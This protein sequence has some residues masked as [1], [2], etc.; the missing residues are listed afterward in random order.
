MSLAGLRVAHARLRLA[1]SAQEE[2]V[3]R[4]RFFQELMEQRQLGHVDDR[5]HALLE[6]LQRM[7]RLQRLSQ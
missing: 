3:V 1:E 2:G 7:E 6:R 4:N 5:M